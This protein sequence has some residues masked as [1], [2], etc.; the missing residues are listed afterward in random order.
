MIGSNTGVFTQLKQKFPWQVG[1]HCL[2]YCLEL[3]VCDAVKACVDMDT[4][5]A[6]YST[7]SSKNKRELSAAAV[8][9]EVCLLKIGR[10]LSTRWVASP[11]RT[12]KVVL[13]NFK[14]F[15]LHFINPSIDST[16][17]FEGENLE[18]VPKM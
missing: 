4:L 17:D 12:V 8:E 16:R 3:A 2:N 18:E 15:Y 7:Q 5:Y 1:W 6:L 14:A 10:V 13:L 11:F 9:V